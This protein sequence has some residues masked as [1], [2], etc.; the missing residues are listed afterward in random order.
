MAKLS[1]GGIPTGTCL[2]CG[3]KISVSWVASTAVILVS[4]WIGLRALFLVMV[5]LVVV[6]S[7]ARTIDRV[8]FYVGFALFLGYYILTP[9][10]L[11]DTALRRRA[12]KSERIGSRVN[13]CFAFV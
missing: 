13:D 5:P 8:V 6:P 3:K 1:T 4:F 9:T 12:K 10:S 2:S 11:T 7:R